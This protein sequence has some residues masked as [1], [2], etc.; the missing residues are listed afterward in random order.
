MHPARYVPTVVLALLAALALAGSAQATIT[1][2]H[3]TNGGTSV[4]NTSFTSGSFNPTQD[5]VALLTINA[6]TSSASQPPTPTVTDNGSSYTWTLVAKSDYDNTGTTDRYTG[7]V[8]KAIITGTRI[9]A[10]VTMN[11]GSTTLDKVDWSLDE[12]TDVDLVNP[13]VQSN[14]V[15][16]SGTSNSAPLGGFA[17]A[18]NDVA[19]ASNYRV[20]AEGTTP[21][22]GLTEITDDSTSAGSVLAVQ[23]EWA[24]GQQSAPGGSWTTTGRA[25]TIALE[26]RKF[27]VPTFPAFVGGV[28]PES[29]N[30]VPMIV[31]ESTKDLYTVNEY[32]EASPFPTIKKS[33]DGGF[34]WNEVDAA[35][36]PTNTG[37][38]AD[39]ESLSLVDD[40]A[41]GASDNTGLVHMLHQ[42]SGT[43]DVYYNSF[44]VAGGDGGQDVWATQGELVTTPT[45]GSTPSDEDVSLLQRHS[46]GDLIAIYQ[47]TKSS[48]FDQ[49]GFKVKPDGGSWGS[50]TILDSTASVNFTQATAV[51]GDSDTAW[52]VYKDDT[53]NALYYKTLSSSGTLSARTQVATS[54]NGTNHVIVSPPVELHVGGS[55]KIVIAW[56]RGSDGKLTSKTIT[57][58]SLGSEQVISDA[59]VWHDPLSTQ[60]VQPVAS[61]A[62]NDTDDKVYAV[63]SRDSDQDAYYDVLS[64]GAWGTDV[65]MVDGQKVASI[66]ATYF[67][68]WNNVNL[69]DPDV[70]GIVYDDE[71]CW[72]P[73][74]PQVANTV[75]YTEIAAP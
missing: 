65:E 7:Y 34:H 10:T 20:T 69:V 61:L 43:K 55:E 22:T 68:N 35:H 60:S 36:R 14:A 25:A 12:F 41:L 47:T 42:R 29:S 72:S 4:D 54:T 64:A 19:Y 5:R 16:V 1:S 45:A 58:G 74:T 46:N 40:T 17:D 59:T 26:L 73:C 51:M 52:I 33:T 30:S 67:P 50:E 53:N 6:R 37:T 23:T 28:F 38:N 71:T 70:L 75:R 63:F 27:V 9:G 8:F 49:I 21:S 66:Q 15:A 44:W 32:T 18:T 62:A 48:G 31:S 3:L 13:I 57:A 24:T 11:F 2:T 39:L 56:K